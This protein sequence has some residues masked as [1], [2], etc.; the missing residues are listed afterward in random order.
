MAEH[1]R[2]EPGQAPHSGPAPSPDQP[3]AGQPPG[4]TAGGGDR[5]HGLGSATA[6]QQATWARSP[7]RRRAVGVYGTIITAAI[8]AAL[9][10]QLPPPKLAVSVVVTLI[11]YWVAEEYAEILGESLTGSRLPTWRYALA[12]LAATWPMVSA[13]AIPLLLLLL[14]WLLGASGYAAANVALV[15]A[16]AELMFYAWRAGR[17]A[18]LPRRQQIGLTSA[19]AVLGLIMI[20]LKDV[21]LINLH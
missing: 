19:A 11:V 21:I 18:R 10:D 3:P 5:P 9:G 13:S 6:S 20:L 7:A 16:V 12:A 17:S 8:L 14:C 15:A 1:T 4:Q 2:A